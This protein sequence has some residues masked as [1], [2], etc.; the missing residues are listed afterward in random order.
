MKK[1]LIAFGILALAIPA[2][3]RTLDLWIGDGTGVPDTYDQDTGD[4]YFEACMELDG[5]LDIDGILWLAD[6]TVLLPGFTFHGDA[7]LDTGF[8]YIGADNF[9]ITAGGVYAGDWSATGLTAIGIDAPIGAVTPAAG[10]FTTVD[11]TDA[12]FTGDIVGGEDFGFGQDPP[13]LHLGF[14]DRSNYITFQ[15]DFTVSVDTEYVLDWDLTTV[16]GGGTNTVS[17]RPGWAEIVTGGAGV[18][19]NST[20]SWGLTNDRAFT[21][22]MESVVELTNLVTQRF[23][24]GFWAA[25]NEFVVISYDVALGANWMLQID[26]NTG[27][28]N[29]DSTVPATVDPTKLEIAVD[30]AGNVTWA[31]DDV[32]MPLPTGATLMTA[33]PHYTWWELTDTAAAAHT[34]AVDYIQIEQLKQQ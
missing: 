14:K 19:S 10:I 11:G 26:D 17:V 7:G 12:T 23:E 13:D 3:G 16:I 1:L 24:W 9:G 15:D 28:E 31:L 18:D 20:R 33:N 27:V 25:A 4:S 21:P 2:Y 5:D 6:G 8:Y 32:A 22:R 30:A 29:V 34:V